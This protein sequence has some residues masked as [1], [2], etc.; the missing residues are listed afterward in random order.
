MITLD[1]IFRSQGSPMLSAIK[2]VREVLGCS[3][4]FIPAFMPEPGCFTM[5][6][7][8]VV[9]NAVQ[10]QKVSPVAEQQTSMSTGLLIGT[11]PK[12]VQRSS[13]AKEALQKTGES[14]AGGHP[15]ESGIKLG[16]FL[17]MFPQISH[18]YSE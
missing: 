2:G 14:S 5:D 15:A 10:T 6:Q 9:L 11:A 7:S 1:I 13:A 8:P 16:S 4:L 17:S 12:A 3:S 18:G